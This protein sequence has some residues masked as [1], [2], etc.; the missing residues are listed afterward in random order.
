MTNQIQVSIPGILKDLDNGMTRKQIK[1]KYDY[2]GKQMSVIFKHPKL[3]NKKAARVPVDIVFVD[4]E[5]E[6]QVATQQE[7]LVKES[8]IKEIKKE[9]GVVIENKID[10]L[11][12][13]TSEEDKEDE[14]EIL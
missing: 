4:F 13:P 5:E 12:D 2:T 11:E 8:T 1:E 7:E 9:M 14:E 10:F 6:K 3:M